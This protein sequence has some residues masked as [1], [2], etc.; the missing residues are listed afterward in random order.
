MECVSVIIPAYNHARYLEEALAS[1]LS[2]RNVIVEVIV[3]D[4]GSVDNTEEVSKRFKDVLYIKQA[5]QGAHA[6]INKGISLARY[7]NIAILN[8]DDLFSPM[9]LDEALDFLTSTGADLV[10]S[11]P[12]LIGYG[13]KLSDLIH[14]Q[15]VS[16]DTLIER[17]SILS[18]LRI[19]WFVSSSGLVFKKD[20][21]SEI[22][23]FRDLKMTHDLDFVL[24]AVFEKNLTLASKSG[25]PWY[26]RCHGANSSSSISAVQVTEELLKILEMPVRK[27]RQG[28]INSSLI[29]F[30]LGHGLSDAQKKLLIEFQLD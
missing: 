7:G 24:R 15:K 8:D 30:L 1:V 25:S 3:V 9:Y 12:Q 2:S 11:E 18:L 29:L 23:G 16:K 20:V 10:A 28:N 13:E 22:G 21:F 27:L 26:Y 5:N 17:G 6:A 14:H 19:N 4:D